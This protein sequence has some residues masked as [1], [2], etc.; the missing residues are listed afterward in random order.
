MKKQVAIVCLV[1]VA[2]VASAQVRKDP[3]PLSG[4][5][6]ELLPP[7]KSMQEISK[8]AIPG[9][10]LRAAQYV[11]KAQREPMEIARQGVAER[12]G[13]PAKSTIFW[14]ILRSS[15]GSVNWMWRIGNN[16]TQK[17]QAPKPAMEMLAELK[18]I[19]RIAD[20]A[21]ELVPESDVRDEQGLR[22]LRFK[23]MYKG[24]P[25]WKR[26]L[27]LHLDKTGEPSII[28]GSY[29]PTPSAVNVTPSLLSEQAV[30]LTIN[31][32]KISGHWAVLDE[33]TMEKLGMH[34]PVAEL[35]LFPESGKF[36][37][38]YDVDVYP[39]LN[40]HY[41]YIVDA[42][43][44]AI[45]RRTPLHC[46]LV[47]QSSPIGVSGFAQ[48]STTPSK[49]LMPLA[50]FSNSTGTDLNGITRNFRSYQHTDNQYYMA[51][52]LA[53][54]SASGSTPPNE[55]KGGGQTFDLKNK[56]ASGQAQIFHVV[57]A[58]NTWSD[59]SAVSAHANM[60]VC[61]DYYRNTFSRNAIDG[62]NGTIISIV[63]V[64]ENN[65]SMGNAYWNGKLMLYGNGDNN[66]KPLA[67]ALD[68][69]GHEMTHGVT[70]NS[71]DLIYEFQS[72]ALN[73]S[74]S[75]VFGVFID[76]NDLTVGEEIMQPGKGTCLRNLE[77]PADPNAL[78]PQ[79]AHMNQFKTL[80]I[81]QDN[82]G[83]H[84]NSGIPN[85]AAA[86][87]INALGRQKAQQIY[88]KALTTYLTRN[89]QFIDCRVACETAAKDIHGD[90]SAEMQAV[91]NAFATVGIGGTPQG[92]NQDDVPAQT[93][94]SEYITFI[95]GSNKIGYLVPST[96]EAFLFS[97]QNAVAR[98]TNVNGNPD[99]CQ[100][101]APRSGKDIWFVDPTGHLAFIE[102]ATGS[103]FNFPNLNIQ[104]NG[105]IWNA[106][107]SPDEEY[108]SLVSSYVNDPNIYIFDGTNIARIELTPESPDGGAQQTIQYPD[109][110]NWSP[111]KWDQRIAF[112]AYNE[113]EFAFGGTLAY[114]SM[115]EINFSTEKIYSLV[116]AQP[117]DV[118]VGNVIYSKTDPDIIAFNVINSQGSDV[119]IGNFENGD[120]FPL[121]IP[122]VAI[123]GNAVV[124][125]DRPCFRPDD[126]YLCF[127][128]A[129][130]KAICFLRAGDGQVTFL[131]F[132]DALYNP[133]W[134]LVGG[135]GAVRSD[136]GHFFTGV[137]V[138][139]S[140]TSKRSTLQFETASS[141]KVTIELID[142]RGSVVR[143]LTTAALNAGS[144]E[145]GL[146][147][148]ELAA[149][150][151]L[152]RLQDGTH[153]AYTKLVI[154]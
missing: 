147:L 99:R 29:E 82:G 88:Y 9:G 36:R 90:G 138:F 84:I 81:E 152:V 141:A 113:E 10:L 46:P 14:K 149:G 49:M 92:D 154:E 47:K 150:A 39:S 77:N 146:D 71:A 45:I 11:G 51:W 129:N 89:S 93:G 139:P 112:D 107:I 148:D 121:G 8:H 60:A 85:H 133:H 143:T 136:D 58:N 145:I 83:V 42:V 144:Q 19:L 111:N 123:G 94:G 57:S 56:D 117:E 30:T 74:F 137:T 103:V 151:Y 55:L 130:N 23:Q 122:N 68:V 3:R 6:K 119:W 135:S 31:D 26:D 17:P 16:G 35:V 69:A 61:Y 125:A 67:G 34:K 37:L 115:Y 114:W 73:E 75:D 98:V 110:M 5:K 24:L 20:P 116:P 86:L 87:I 72:G 63:N 104:Q 80:T 120:M 78:D 32:L 27:Y 7:S 65:Q 64:T 97:D 100:L 95:G 102:S 12:S 91:S 118:N 38:A 28:N 108:V 105:D 15:N 140:V 153:Q 4:L 2:V 43:S 62:K 131:A 41:R 13:A 33:A 134:F 128:S 1:V 52:D 132:T 48:A 25:V 50:G 40:E 59:K 18:N 101:S 54:Y 22:H 126:S 106:S 109:V 70:G 44:G 127:T 53:S 66:F 79:P 76:N 96:G 124:D 142:M 21:T